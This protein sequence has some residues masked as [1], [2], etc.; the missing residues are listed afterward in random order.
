MCSSHRAVWEKVLCTRCTLIVPCSLP[1]PLPPLFQPADIPV[2]QALFF[3][4]EPPLNN[5]A[6]AD[7][8]RRFNHRTARRG[9][10]S[11]LAGA[12]TFR[13]VNICPGTLRGQTIGKRTARLFQPTLLC[14]HGEGFF[15]PAIE[16]AS[17]KRR[18]LISFHVRVVRM[19]VC[20]NSILERVYSERVR[21]KL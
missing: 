18:S 2:G 7:M 16:T 3:S 11:P 5:T 17:F 20:K 4:V 8:E 6:T 14:V 9:P 19:Y 13:H 21:S 12:F 1:P 10:P 15:S